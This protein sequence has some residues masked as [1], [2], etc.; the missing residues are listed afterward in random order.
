MPPTAV[1]AGGTFRRI[2][3]ALVAL[4]LVTGVYA[5][6]ELGT[7]LAR[8]DPLEKAD[9][10][11][12][13]SGTSMRR[14]LEGA[15]LFL[16]GYGSRL[17]LTRQ[18]RDGGE[19]ALAKRGVALPE[20]VELQ[21]DV[22]VKLGVPEPSIIIP[23]R[24]HNSTAAEAVTLRELAA[25]YGWTTVIVV[26]SPYHLRRSGFALRRE[27]RGTGVRVVMRRTRYEPVQPERWWGRRT[28][29][30]DVVSEI[31]KLVAYMAGLGA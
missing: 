28:D 9:A 14:P 24:I 7:F 10:I 2:V 23:P 16:A 31:P 18:T 4:I 22:F 25:K 6:I 8:E 11:L 3:V 27:L 26:T 30:R 19:L 1:R 13:L 15:D 21:R 17:V 29:V 12:V 5:F 20:D